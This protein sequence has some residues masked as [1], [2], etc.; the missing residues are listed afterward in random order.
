MRKFIKKYL[1][2]N[3]KIAQN[4]SL[5]YLTKFF[6]DNRLWGLNRHSFASA[7]SIG[8]FV[9][10]LPMPFQMLVAAV[11]AIIFHS[12]LPVSVG[13]VWV[14]NPLTMPVIF[15]ANY[16]IGSWIMGIEYKKA[17]AEKFF[18]W[19][20]INISEI[21]PP[22]ILGSIITGIVLAIVGNVLVRLLWRWSVSVR[23]QKRR[24]RILQRIKDA[25]EHLHHEKKHQTQEIQEIQETQEQNLSKNTQDDLHDKSQDNSQNES[26]D[27]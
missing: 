23:W 7:V 9:G 8:L 3:E 17:S 12:N 14:T 6:K 19:L 13:L 22:L 16:K 18:H 15:Y 10:M 2:E 26:Q 11:L 27:K 20:K 24:E 5:R 21:M 25:K 1:P 4:K